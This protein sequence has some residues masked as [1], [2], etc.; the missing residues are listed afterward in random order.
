MHNNFFSL[1]VH[2]SMDPGFVRAPRKPVLYRRI[3]QG[4]VPACVRKGLIIMEGWLMVSY[5]KYTYIYFFF[6]FHARVRSYAAAPFPSTTPLFPHSLTIF[7]QRAPTAAASQVYNTVL[8]YGIYTE[9]VWGEKL[10]TYIHSCIKTHAHQ[11]R[12]SPILQGRLLFA[13]MGL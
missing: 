6:Q 5:I 12:V 13:T 3:L 4:V 2:T 1:F 11:P 9:T 8:L 7:L 10:F